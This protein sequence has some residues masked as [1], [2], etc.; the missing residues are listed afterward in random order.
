MSHLIDSIRE[1]PFN[2]LIVCDC[3]AMC[4]GAVQNMSGLVT[5]RTLLSIFEAGFGSGAPYC[6][7]LFY[8]RREL[9]LRVSLLLGMYPHANGF[10]ASLAYEITSIKKFSDRDMATSLPDLPSSAKFLSEEE[11]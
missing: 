4:S 2:K 3:T 1:F 5:C 8:Q 9:G 6:L 7:P 11:Q 10:A